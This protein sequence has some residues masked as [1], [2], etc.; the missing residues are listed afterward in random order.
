AHF[1]VQGKKMAKSLG[2]FF[3]LRDLL[4][5][6]FSGRDI[7]CLLL[8]AYYRE[9]F[10]FILEGLSAARASLARIDDCLRKLRELARPVQVTEIPPLVEQFVVALDDDLNVSAAW[11]AIFD[12]VRETNRKLSEGAMD[13][14]AAAIALATWEKL[15]S[16][17][18]VGV[19]PEVEVP[20]E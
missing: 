19:L 9:T 14:N 11:A 6:G 13:A 7:R 16:V 18:G 1:L 17:L 15:D 8:S 2:N 10:N 5:K 3:T 12:A 4:A 20:A